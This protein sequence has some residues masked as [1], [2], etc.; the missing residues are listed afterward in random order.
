MLNIKSANV[1]LVVVSEDSNSII[2]EEEYRNVQY[3]SHEDIIRYFPNSFSQQVDRALLSLCKVYPDYDSTIFLKTGGAQSEIF[4]NIENGSAPRIR[5]LVFINYDLTRETYT[6]IR[7]ITAFLDLLADM[8]FLVKK[9]SS[10]GHLYQIASKGWLR[11]QEIQ[12]TVNTSKQAFVAMW[13]D[14]QNDNAWETIS[15]AIRD[16]GYNPVRIDKKEHNN[17]IVPEILFEIRQSEFIVADLTKNRNGVYYEAGYAQALGKEVIV[18]WKKTNEKEDQPHFDVAQ[19]NMI[20]WDNDDEL[21]I[22]LVKR[23]KATVRLPE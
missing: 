1:D 8:E 2:I 6:N 19:K 15:K 18:T 22:G 11:I 12:K 7:K 17:Q 14:S 21:Y 23:I 5:N 20:R 9:G 16:C 4:A 3:I 13:F 10:S